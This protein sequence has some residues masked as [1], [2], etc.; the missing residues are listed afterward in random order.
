VNDLWSPFLILGAAALLGGVIGLERELRGGWAGLRTHMLV[1]MA[2]AMFVLIGTDMTDASSA[3]L[4]RIIQGIAAGIGFI[5][6]GTILKLTGRLEIKGLTT[7]SS[8]W[9]AS[10]VGAA[11]G[12]R[13]FLVA[14]VAALLSLVILYAVGKLERLFPSHV[15]H[16]SPMSGEDNGKRS[17]DELHTARS[18]HQE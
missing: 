9:L 11:C 17:H 15:Q 14:G 16:V 4:S 12:V 2:A 3:D 5:G 13:L 18:T 8:I 10:A 6:A 7:A 1:A